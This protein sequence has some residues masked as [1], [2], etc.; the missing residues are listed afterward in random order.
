MDE[1]SN[2][3]V[4]GDWIFIIWRIWPYKESDVNAQLKF[5]ALGFRWCHIY[6]V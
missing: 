6:V 2:R 4:F 3:G 1:E 5:G